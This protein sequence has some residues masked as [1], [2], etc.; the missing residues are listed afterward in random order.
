MRGSVPCMHF[1]KTNIDKH[2]DPAPFGVKR[3]RGKLILTFSA[4]STLLLWV[5]MH[6]ASAFPA[7][8]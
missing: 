1:S 6:L 8:M 4:R 5:A 2:R 7:T 3:H